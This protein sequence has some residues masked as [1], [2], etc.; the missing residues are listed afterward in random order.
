MLKRWR[1]IPYAGS[2]IC[3]QTYL[4]VWRGSKRGPQGDDPERP[5]QPSIGCTIGG[6]REELQNRCKTRRVCSVFE[7]QRLPGKPLGT[8]TS[9]SER[10]RGRQRKSEGLTCCDSRVLDV[11]GV[12]PQAESSTTTLDVGMAWADLSEVQVRMRERIN[13]LRCILRVERET[14]ERRSSLILSYKSGG[15]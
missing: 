14:S 5:G 4:V 8:N 9:R 7:R 6:Y 10:L 3:G 13:E 15:G 2:E 11:S 1:S 12:I